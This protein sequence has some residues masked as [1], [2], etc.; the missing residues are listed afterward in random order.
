MTGIVS[1]INK[2]S[3]HPKENNIF[4]PKG[5]M[6]RV[7]YAWI[8]LSSIFFKGALSVLDTYI[9]TLDPENISLGVS[10]AALFVYA[11]A[12]VYSYVIIISGAKRSR[13]IGNS[14]LMI[15]IPFY[16]LYLLFVPTKE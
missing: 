10:L 4:V 1:V 13:D 9:G 2:Y 8:F 15:I 11:L 12:F 5:R 14:G 3:H 7:K 16:L 6:D